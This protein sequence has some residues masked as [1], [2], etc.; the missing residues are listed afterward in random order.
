MK[1][2]LENSLNN[3]SLG[4]KNLLGNVK[5]VAPV[6]FFGN[7]ILLNLILAGALPHTPL[8]NLTILSETHLL[9]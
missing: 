8:R 4:L 3:V 7:Q 6:G 1:V 2:V 9:F 5:C